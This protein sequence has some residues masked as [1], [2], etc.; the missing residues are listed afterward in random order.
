MLWTVRLVEGAG[1]AVSPLVALLT[2]GST[3]AGQNVTARVSGA[4]ALEGGAG[5]QEGEVQTG[6][7]QDQEDRLLRE[8]Q[9][10]T[11]R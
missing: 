9:P 8:V 1:P 11:R 10:T 3:K 2:G 7:D 4:L 6:E 5:L